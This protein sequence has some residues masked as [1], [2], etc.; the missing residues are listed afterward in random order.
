MSNV[1]RYL[2]ARHLGFAA[3]RHEQ[4]TS[5]VNE[6]Y[7]LAIPPWKVAKTIVLDVAGR[8]VVAVLPA[9][10]RIDLHRVRSLMGDP[11]VRLAGEAEIAEAFPQ[12]E[13]GAIPPLSALTGSITLVDPDIARMESVVFAAGRT[14][15][16]IR[17]AVADLLDAPGVR[18]APITVQPDSDE[19]WLV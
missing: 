14:D 19:D 1:S 3:I 10:R 17:L 9:D 15:E 4:T 8:H 12:F 2:E 18:V 7:A 11:Q 16:S 5:A 6:A 13:L